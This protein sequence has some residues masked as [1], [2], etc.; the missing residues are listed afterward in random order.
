MID[1]YFRYV[2]VLLLTGVFALLAYNIFYLLASV[3]DGGVESF[4]IEETER[5]TSITI[6]AN[7]EEVLLLAGDNGNW[8]VEG[9]GEAD[10]VAISSLMSFLRNAGI[11][12]PIPLSE[13]N[14]ANAFI[15][16][17]GVRVD[18]FVHDYWIK[19]PGGHGLIPRKKN[20]LAFLVGAERDDGL[21]TVMRL[22]GS[23][24]AYE[25]NI[26]GGSG[27]LRSR[28]RHEH[29]LWRNPVVVSLLADEL[30]KVQ[31][32]VNGTVNESFVLDRDE[33]RGFRI[34]DFKGTLIDM[35][36]VDQRR[37]TLFARS[38]YGL[39]YEKLL[40]EE[41][42]R[43]LDALMDDIPFMTVMVEGKDMEKIRLDCFYL[44]VSHA[45]TA[46]PVFGNYDPNRFVLLVDNQHYAIAQFLVFNRILR[47]LSF[48]LSE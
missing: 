39:F 5:I 43:G 37:L 12:R 25:V 42:L 29:T 26:A 17:R 2:L 34:A 46:L 1:K 13:M 4:S 11:R 24:Q 19:L 32:L 45:D 41:D 20:A 28:F 15:D 14:Q 44:D 10:Q 33:N 9:H 16:A 47:P 31:V 3:P 8:M 30:E 22:A 18:V 36:R 21:A 27:Q 23:D 7:G 35:Q 38:F 40:G 48:F 6:A